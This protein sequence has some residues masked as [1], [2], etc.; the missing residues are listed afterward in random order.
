MQEV[1][2]SVFTAGVFNIMDQIVIG[3]L[4]RLNGMQ[5]GYEFLVWCCKCQPQNAFRFRKSL[6]EG[7][8]KAIDSADTSWIN[9]DGLF[10][11][12]L[13]L[14]SIERP[15][16]CIFVVFR[17]DPDGSAS[18]HA[19]PRS[20]ILRIEYQQLSKVSKKLI[21]AK[22]TLSDFSED[23]L[24]KDYNLTLELVCR[25]CEPRTIPKV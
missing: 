19:V 23:F 5:Y 7:L 1:E 12:Q 2:A 9:V 15:W 8:A 18:T 17:N 25:S 21:F 4:C 24:I 6:N 13:A 16:T 20:V 3:G 14:L 22:I 11:V 10:L